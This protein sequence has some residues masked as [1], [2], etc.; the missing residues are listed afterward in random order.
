MHKSVFET[1]LS[2]YVRIKRIEMGNKGVLGCVETY[3]GIE[4]FV[5]GGKWMEMSKG[6]ESS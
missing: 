1:I 4:I 3:R 5:V 6:V 2:E